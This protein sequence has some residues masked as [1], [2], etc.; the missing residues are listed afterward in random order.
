MRNK[1]L[2]TLVSVIFISTA[3]LAEKEDEY[4][5][6]DDMTEVYNGLTDKQRK[7]IIDFMNFFGFLIGRSGGGPKTREEE[8]NNEKPEGENHEPEL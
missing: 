1:K 6:K 7:K 2:L 3:V 4:K 5:P 8:N